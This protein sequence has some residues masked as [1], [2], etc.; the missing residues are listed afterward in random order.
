MILEEIV[1]FLLLFGFSYVIMGIHT[2]LR[3]GKY[4]GI[5]EK[6]GEEDI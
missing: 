4:E 1:R 2:C 5:D 3:K 6:R